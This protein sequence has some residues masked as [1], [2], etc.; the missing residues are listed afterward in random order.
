MCTDLPPPP[1]RV[2]FVE[3]SPNHI[4]FNWSHVLFICPLLH[5]RI[6]ASNCGQCPNT[7]VNTTVTCRGNNTK[8][9]NSA[10][11]SFAVQTVACGETAGDV[12]MAVNV[13]MIW[14]DVHFS[15]TMTKDVTQSASTQTEVVQCSS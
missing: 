10:P 7:T 13:I 15:P 8:L 1:I 3:E 2:N 5:Y 12:S 11:C 4:R 6:V 14:R 9:S